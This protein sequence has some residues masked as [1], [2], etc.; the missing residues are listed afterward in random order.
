MRSTTCI[1]TPGA[2]FTVVCAPHS[3]PPKT[4]RRVSLRTETSPLLLEPK[5]SPP[6]LEPKTSPP[7]LEPKTSPLLLVS[8]PPPKLRQEPI[9]GA[10]VIRAHDG[11]PHVDTANPD[12]VEEVQEFAERRL[13]PAGNQRLKIIPPKAVVGHGKAMKCIGKAVNGMADRA[14]QSR[15][16]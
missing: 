13:R 9:A 7:L 16:S 6:L 8:A 1:H 2:L 11:G 12:R 5:T 10:H 14:E 3:F 15:T 4:V